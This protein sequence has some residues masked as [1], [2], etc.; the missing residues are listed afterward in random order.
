MIRNGRRLKRY[1]GLRR[2]LV[3]N[4]FGGIEII[5]PGLISGWV[6]EEK[7]IYT[8]VKLVI[9]ETVL[10]KANIDQIRSDVNELHDFQDTPGFVIH[11]PVELPKID[12]SNEIKVIAEDPDLNK[13]VQLYLLNKKKNTMQILSD[14]FKSKLLGTVGNI[15]GYN[16]K[17]K[18]NGW[19]AKKSQP[20]PSNV[21]L[22][23]SGMT[24][25]MFLASEIRPD[26][27]EK[28]YPEKCGFSIFIDEL[29]R[30]WTGKHVFCTFDK[31]GN[32]P[33][34]S[35]F[36]IVLPEY[37]S[38]LDLKELNID[39]NVSIINNKNFERNIS[40]APS[41]LKDHWRSLE[42][43]RLYLEK[44]EEEIDILENSSTNKLSSKNKKLIFFKFKNFFIKK[45]TK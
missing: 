24:P 14:I 40:S 5:T 19:V 39:H 1:L 22:Q 20:N 43:F 17:Y 10:T 9:G 6:C 7:A 27:K 28:G 29:P 2:K 38:T 31:E 41:E 18:I 36:K 23:A 16:D 33:L 42:N 26:I 21:W 4:T 3:P 25:L 34:P 44:I 8:Q 12:F 30:T 35:L 32:F 15:D 45:K 13:T 11:L 37:S